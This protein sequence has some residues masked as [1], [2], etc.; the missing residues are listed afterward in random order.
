MIV[1][2][3]PRCGEV[4]VKEPHGYECY[5]CGEAILEGAGLKE[6]EDALLEA[7]QDPEIIEID[8]MIIQIVNDGQDDLEE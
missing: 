3:C 8:E 1:I 2:N 4:M 7:P 5:A 6:R